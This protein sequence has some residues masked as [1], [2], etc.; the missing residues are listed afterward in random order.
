MIEINY[1]EKHGLLYLDLKLPKQF[2]LSRFDYL[3]K[4]Y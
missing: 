3:R 1:I 4:E 2:T